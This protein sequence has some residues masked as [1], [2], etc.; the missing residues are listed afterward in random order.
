[1]PCYFVS[2]CSVR[3][4]LPTASPFKK[5]RLP[6][7]CLQRHTNATARPP[8]AS[9]RPGT[10]ASGQES[11]RRSASSQCEPHT[12]PPHPPLLLH[13][14]STA[15]LAFLLAVDPQLLLLLRRRRRIRA[16]WDREQTRRRQRVQCRST[17]VAVIMEEETQLGRHPQP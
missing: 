2:S 9:G 12:P 13:P 17:M 10:T 5:L 4:S 14:P 15:K 8:E 3:L 7:A 6:V 16:P 1:M 11:S